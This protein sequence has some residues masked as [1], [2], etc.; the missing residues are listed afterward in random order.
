MTVQTNRAKTGLTGEFFVYSQLI[1]HDK[2]G[3]IT[4]GNAKAVD[5][6]I[7]DSNKRAYYI[8]VK[9][10]STLMKNSHNHSN[11]SDDIGLIGRWQLKLK[12]FWQTHSKNPDKT[13]YPFPDFYI[14]HNCQRPEKNY[15]LKGVDFVQIM[16]GKI[17]SIISRFDS[18]VLLPKHINSQCDLCEFCFNQDSLNNWSMLP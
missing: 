7:V 10:T 14:F 6:I 9:S 17:D 11:Y 4:L 1:K 16:H 13:D 18:S 15:I 3:F 8:D 5:I 12:P 2:N